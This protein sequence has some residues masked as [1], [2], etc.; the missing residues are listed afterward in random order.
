[1]QCN[2]LPIRERSSILY[3]WMATEILNL[4]LLAMYYPAYD[5]GQRS[6]KP[7]SKH[8]ERMILPGSSQKYSQMYLLST[9]ELRNRL[10]QWSRNW[11]GRGSHWL[12][13]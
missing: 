10:S 3:L 2:P 11:E 5:N 9:R 4:P 13:Q 7:Q 6:Y 1:M 12:P 8:A